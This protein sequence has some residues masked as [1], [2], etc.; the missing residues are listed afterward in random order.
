[1]QGRGWQRPPAACGRSAGRRKWGQTCQSPM[2]PNILDHRTQ[3][4]RHAVPLRSGNHVFTQTRTAAVPD[5]LHRDGIRAMDW[6]P[7]KCWDSQPRRFGF[8][9]TAEVTQAPLVAVPILTLPAACML[10]PYAWL[11]TVCA[12]SMKSVVS[13]TRRRA[14]SGPMPS[15][16]SSAARKKFSAN[17]FQ[18]LPP[19]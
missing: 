2:F 7:L 5:P 3:R 19:S 9:D 1:M 6:K 14:C 8:P 10:V 12:C 11:N 17:G 18:N 13:S 4:A 16:F 15:I